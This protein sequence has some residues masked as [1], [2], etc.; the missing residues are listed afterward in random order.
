M[1]LIHRTSYHLK[2]AAETWNTTSWFMFIDVYDWFMKWLTRHFPVSIVSSFPRLG[3]WRVWNFYWQH[4]LQTKS[5]ILYGSSGDF[6]ERCS[7]RGLSFNVYQRF[8]V[9]DM[10][11]CD[12][13]MRRWRPPVG[14]HVSLTILSSYTTETCHVNSRWPMWRVGST[15]WST[16]W[17]FPVAVLPP[18]R[19]CTRNNYRTTKKA[20]RN[21]VS[22]DSFGAKPVGQAHGRF[23]SI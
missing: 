10:R 13:G 15:D 19:L 20:A 2:L 18:S 9:D 14:E 4:Q 12:W 11:R 21:R 6:R 22:W 1:E 16:D 7:L 5:M 23:V 8:D 3:S 17:T